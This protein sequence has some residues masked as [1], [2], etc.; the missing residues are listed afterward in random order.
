MSIRIDSPTHQNLAA[1]RAL[2]VRGLPGVGSH[3]LVLIFHLSVQPPETDTYLKNLAIRVDYGDDAQRM[4]GFALPEAAQPIVISRYTNELKLCFR[5]ALAPNQVEAIEARRNG[6]D[7]KIRVWMTGEVTQGEGSCSFQQAGEYEVV[8]QEWVEALER[9]EF[10]HSMLFEVVFPD[11]LE[12]GESPLSIIKRAQNQLL[13][14]HY[15]NCVG[16]C[17]KLLEAYPVDD[18]GQLNAARKKYKGARDERE[19]M[20]VVERLLVLRDTLTHATHP[21][22]HHTC[23]GEYSRD[24]ARA[25]LA[26]TVSLVAID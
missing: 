4:I 11:K 18:P 17:R 19:S 5:I 14:G 13:R 12:S 3:T 25:I 15:D 24:Q 9:M 10:R 26:V 22:H 21:A 23:S 7:F 16:E 2:N 1:V 20:D 8:Q 6:G